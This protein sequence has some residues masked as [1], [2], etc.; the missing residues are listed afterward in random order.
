MCSVE[1]LAL[2]RCGIAV[3]IASMETTSEILEKN[4][5]EQWPQQLEK[6]ASEQGGWCEKNLR[7]KFEGQ[8]WTLNMAQK[9]RV[10]V[11][12]L[13][14]QYQSLKAWCIN[15]ANPLY[16]K[17]LNADLT[18]PSGTTK[19]DVMRFMRG[20]RLAPGTTQEAGLRRQT[21]GQGRSH[22]QC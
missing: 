6:A 10:D 14:P 13:W 5:G 22:S 1:Q 17:F 15:V 21:Q 11:K 9:V 16:V 18:L 12:R 20:V 8:A 7:K 19:E 2:L 4:M 3:S